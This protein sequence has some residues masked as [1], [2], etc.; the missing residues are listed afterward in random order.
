MAGKVSLRAHTVNTSMRAHEVDQRLRPLIETADECHAVSG[1]YR[2]RFVRS[3]A[4]LQFVIDA[5][6]ANPALRFQMTKDHTGARWL[7]IR[8]PHEPAG[9]SPGESASRK[10]VCCVVA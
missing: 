10:V 1:G 7:E 2:V 6:E 4:M 9:R 3:H 5:I 8:M